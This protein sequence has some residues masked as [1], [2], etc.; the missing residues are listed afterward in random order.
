MK[1]QVTSIEQ[2]RRLL[3]L[4]VSA[5]KASM[6]WE[7]WINQDFSKDVPEEVFYNLNTKT[8]READ[9]CDR[10]IPAFTVVDLLKMM[11]GFIGE[12]KSLFIERRSVGCSGSKWYIGYRDG[13]TL[14]IGSKSSLLDVCTLGIEWLLSNGYKLEL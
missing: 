6:V 5:E 12:N 7:Y 14:W 8:N 3:E 2:S 13:V 1:D 9:S 11:P 4:G 10:D